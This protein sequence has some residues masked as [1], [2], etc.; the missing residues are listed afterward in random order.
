MDR[1]FRFNPPPPGRSSVMRP[2]LVQALAARFERRLVTV[3]AGAG[4]GKTTLLGQAVV[5]NRLSPRGSDCWLTCEPVDSSASILLGAIVLALGRPLPPAAPT[6]GDVCEAVWTVAPTEV[7]LVLDDTHHLEAGSGGETAVRELLEALPANGHLLVAGRRLPR[8]AASRLMAHG[9]ALELGED[10]LRLDPAE[11]ALLA[12]RHEVDAAVLAG[13]GG[14][15]ALAELYASTGVLHAERFVW[16]EVLEPLPE[17]DRRAFRRVV[18]VGGASGDTL[19]AVVDGPYDAERLAGLPLV[20]TD[21]RGGV[22]PHPLWE[23]LIGARLD[24]DEATA[25]RRRLAA[26][27]QAQ[28]EFGA[29][30]ELL[31]AVGDWDRAVEAVFDAC[32]DQRAP[33]WRDQ[34][35]R[36][37]QLIPT[38]LAGRPEAVYLQAMTERGGDT[39]SA[40]AHSCFVEALAGFQ[41]RGDIAREIAGSVRASHGAW[42][43]E[44]SAWLH[45]LGTRANELAAA[46]LPLEPLILL[47][48]AAVADI[49]GDPAEVIA[50]MSRIGVLE[51][52]LRHYPPLFRVLA[53]LTAGDADAA[54]ADAEAAATAA[55]P[56][57]PASGTGWGASLA[58]ALVAWCRGD[59]SAAVA[60]ELVDPGARQSLVERLPTIALA[61]IIAAHH[62]DQSAATTAVG[63]LD[64]LVPDIGDRHLVAGL[65][66]V[67][68]AATAVASGD[69]PGATRCLAEHLDGRPLSPSGAG[70]AIRWFP[71]LPY[72]LHRGSRE[73]LDELPSGPSRRRAIDVCS[74]LMAVRAGRPVPRVELA[75]DADSLLTILPL[76]LALELTVGVDAELGAAALPVI[77]RLAELAPSGARAALHRLATDG[78][79]PVR[80]AARTAL[81]SVPIAPTHEVRIEVL[82]PARLLRNREGSDDANWRRLRVRQT[83]CALVLHPR[84][85]RAALGVLLWPDADER[86]VSANL[87][88]TLS[89][90]QALLEPDRGRGDAPWFLQ[91]DEGVLTLSGGDYLSVDAWEFDAHLSSASEA[92]AAALPSVELDRLLAA[93]SLWRGEPFVDVSGAHWAEP[94][95]ERFRRRFVMAAARAGELLVADGRP[96]R[97]AALAAMAVEVDPWS[98]PSH[99]LLASARLA[100]GDRGGARQ[101]LEAGLRMLAELEVEPDPATLAL[102]AR[103]GVDE[104]RR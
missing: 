73:L 81:N 23:D 43:R 97:A 49:E 94:V 86:G 12:A 56:M 88:M 39:R 16:E 78:R 15:P 18:A 6:V 17:A 50:A 35:E 75:N 96:E 45:G 20:A 53:Y 67:V 33:P 26:A 79:E 103:S 70:R 91:Q 58:P 41:R 37:R 82:G 83:V 92:A 59:R 93:T 30:F 69:E 62:G 31:A 1:P 27:L 77:R 104:T 29:A 14:W 19:D 44:D 11:V 61:G 60:H 3:E 57:A 36:W 42:I 10:D 66:G 13:A 24:A 63:L 32:N 99:R 46:G 85:T 101:A 48:R 5:E 65:R 80:R 22:R 47:N 95:R 72:L 76:P 64:A 38:E 2:R 40:A 54:V 4:L 71:A 68:A 34:M 89:Y 90:L 102:C 74:A 8:L 98:E 25:A 52:R 7:C 84:M 9:R 55:A 28:G 100:A 21:G 87:R 51:P